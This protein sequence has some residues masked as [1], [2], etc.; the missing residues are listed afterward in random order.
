M[1]YGLCKHLR[2]PVM[3]FLLHFTVNSRGHMWDPELMLGMLR[4]CGLFKIM[5]L[6]LTKESYKLLGIVLRESSSRSGTAAT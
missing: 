6:G 5:R 1:L 3:S 4:G 2:I